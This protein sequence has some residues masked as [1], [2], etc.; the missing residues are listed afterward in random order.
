MLIFFIC[1]CYYNAKYRFKYF[2]SLCLSLYEIKNQSEIETNWNRREIETNLKSQSQAF[3]R[4]YKCQNISKEIYLQRLER[5]NHTYAKLVEH[6]MSKYKWSA[7]S[8]IHAHKNNLFILLHYEF[9]HTFNNRWRYRYIIE[10]IFRNA[11]K[12]MK[13]LVIF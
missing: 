8:W 9:I 5:N 2:S 1:Q 12:I 3:D 7:A 4:I 13:Y 6:K 11:T 10:N